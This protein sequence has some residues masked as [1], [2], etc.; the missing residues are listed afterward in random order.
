M[1]D[2]YS[3]PRIEE[4]L[5][6]LNGV[7]WFTSLDLK[8]G[9]LQVKLD[10][11]N[12]ALTTFTVGPLG[13]YQC[14]RIPFGLTNALATFQRL[15]ESC[16]GDMHLKWVIIYLDDIIIFSKTPKE[17][18]QR[19]RGVFQ[20]LHEV[21]LKLKPKKCEFF[22]TRISYLGH[23]V[24]RSGIECD[25]KKIEAIK[26]WKRPTTVH[27]VRSFL[28]FTNYYR[29]FIH[30]YAQISGENATKK[31]KKVEW[32]EKCDKAFIAL[33]KQCCNPPILSYADYGKPFKLHTDASGLELGAILYQTQED[34]TDRVIAY[35]NR[36]LS[37]SEK[38]YP[39]YK[40]EFLALKWSVCDRFHECLYGGRFE[41]F[42]DNNPL[43]YILTTAKLDATGQR[44]VANLANY[45]FSI[46]YK[47][48]KSNVDA[49]ALSRNPWDMQV[50]TAIVMSII[51]EERSTQTP[52]Y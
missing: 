8:L 28:G 17:H 25:P 26:N 2:A 52:L 15:M 20:K 37:K 23:I 19:L 49:D 4:T 24:S 10:E 44:W 1:K 43:T 9:D 41:V 48:G 7:Q 3:L 22:K 47:S 14:E 31:H 6:C 29:R 45:T 46:K 42:T 11:E 39:A 38:N 5:D 32:D 33:K 16:L 27:D 35:A 30:K 51:N 34:G 18:I 36:T 40:L 12:K 50:D 13:F 21:G